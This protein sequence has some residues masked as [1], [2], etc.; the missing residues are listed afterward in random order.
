MQ[1]GRQYISSLLHAYPPS[2][3]PL[4]ACAISVVSII[5][6]ESDPAQDALDFPF[7]EAL[8]ERAPDRTRI[9]DALHL[10][11][12]RVAYRRAL[13]RSGQ[14]P[15]AGNDALRVRRPEL[16]ERA[17]IVDHALGPVAVGHN[18]RDPVPQLLRAEFRLRAAPVIR[19]RKIRNSRRSAEFAAICRI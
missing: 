15:V 3:H 6:P 12:K 18:D 8:F 5:D 16:H 11:E 14:G 1:K 17:Q 19:Q 4:K 13:L 2:P 9:A 7:D 10:F